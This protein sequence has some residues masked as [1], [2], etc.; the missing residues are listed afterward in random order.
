MKCFSALGFDFVGRVRH[1]N[2]R[3]RSFQHVQIVYAV[4][5]G[6]GVGNVNSKFFADNLNR[7]TFVNA[8]CHH[9]KNI[10]VVDLEIKK[11]FQRRDAIGNI[12]NIRRGEAGKFAEFPFAEVAFQRQNFID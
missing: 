3:A 12:R 6:K 5:N 11:F 7:R 1:C 8:L 10:G 4:A 2:R 9:F